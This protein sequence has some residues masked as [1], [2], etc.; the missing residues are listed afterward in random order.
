[1]K[2]TAEQVQHVARL[3]RLSI[4]PEATERL[5]AELATILTY[6]DKLSEVD[7]QGVP[8]TSHAIALTNA[9]RDDMVHDHLPREQALQNAPSQDEGNFVVPKVI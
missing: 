2:I 1:M 4:D 9:F 3:A 5:A 7:T 6:V 8:P